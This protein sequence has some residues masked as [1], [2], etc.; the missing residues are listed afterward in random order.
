MDTIIKLKSEN[1][2]K[3]LEQ[4]YLDS[5]TKNNYNKLNS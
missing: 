4:K 3:N 1:K 5:Q 2:K